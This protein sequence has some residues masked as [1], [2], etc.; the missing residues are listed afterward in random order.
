MSEKGA[1][2]ATGTDVDPVRLEVF[3]HLLSSVAEEMGTVLRRTAYSPNIKER[4]DY[5]CAL[6]DDRARMVAQAAHIPVHLGSMSSAVGSCTRELDLGPGDVALVNDPFRGGTHLPDLTLVAPVHLASG[7]ERSGLLGYV[8]ARA[9]HADV[10]GSAPGSMALSREIYEEGL[11][12]PPVRLVRGGEWDEEL[13]ELLLANVRTPGERAGD[14]RAQVGAVRRGQERF[15]EL[16]GRYGVREL[17]RYMSAL[18]GYAERTV[19]S[20]VDELPD[21]TYR[22]RDA[23]DDDGWSEEPAVIAV[24]VS[25]EDDRLTVDFRASDPQREGSVNAVRSITVSAVAYVVR[26]LV[27]LDVPSNDGCL[28]PVRVLT[29]GG[30]IVDARPPAAVAGGNVET[31]QRMVDVLLGAFAE[32]C[33]D[34]VPAASQG[35]MNNLTLGGR[36]SGGE[37]RWAYYETVAGG[38]GGG[39]DGPGASALHSHMTN[40]LNTPVE[41][42]EFAYPLRVL[43]YAVRRGSG[44]EGRHPGGDGVIRELEVLVES[45]LTLLTERRRRGPY[46]LRGGAEGE[47]GRNVLVR[48][49]VEE[50]LPGKGTWSLRP[51]DRIRLETPGGGG[52]GSDAG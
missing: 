36:A 43:R 26:C 50:E 21:G 46:G 41:A 35:T 6:F 11:V 25:V 44:G 42:L 18:L 14:L 15:R 37:R 19:R 16:A 20:L 5:S 39:P 40:T 22:F 30:T 23:M 51:G 28:A 47:P 49:G 32:A 12:I 13:L 29:T 31:S 10:G 24:E 17:R 9:H 7:S 2:S 48:D 3:K 1:S 4:R 45:R 27:G 34:A 33:P 38:V 52:W 8:A